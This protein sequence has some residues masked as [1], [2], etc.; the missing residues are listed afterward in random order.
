MVDCS[1]LLR[2]TETQPKWVAGYLTYSG[3][4]YYYVSCNTVHRSTSLHCVYSFCFCNTILF[5]IY[6]W[7]WTIL[8][9]RHRCSSKLQMFIAS[10]LNYWI[11]FRNNPNKI[12]T[13]KNVLNLWQLNSAI[14]SYVTGI[15]NN[16]MSTLQLQ[17]I[18][19]YE[20]SYNQTL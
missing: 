15:W 17:L 6:M 2:V 12:S 13:I 19:T 18:A 16:A 3:Y 20:L 7:C 5:T 1:W 8:L 9:H 11:I 10:N 14:Q 4:I